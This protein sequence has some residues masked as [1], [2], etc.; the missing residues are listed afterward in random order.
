MSWVVLHMRATSNCYGVF[1]LQSVQVVLRF[2]D[3]VDRG[4][5]DF[6]MG[7]GIARRRMCNNNGAGPY[8]QRDSE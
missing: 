1:G 6:K 4:R 2:F 5:L 7:V 3:K 8:F